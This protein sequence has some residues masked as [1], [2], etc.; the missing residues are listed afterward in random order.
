V[1]GSRRTGADKWVS[2]GGA[3]G[4]LAQVASDALPALSGRECDGTPQRG[5][6]NDASIK[7]APQ[8]NACPLVRTGVFC[9]PQHKQRNC[10]I[11]EMY[12]ENRKTSGRW[13]S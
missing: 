12:E 6:S 7:V 3:N 10:G 9:L 11:S 8:A 5:C 4:Y 1:L 13:V 2:E